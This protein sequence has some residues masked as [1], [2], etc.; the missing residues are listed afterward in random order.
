MKL[1]SKEEQHVVSGADLLMTQI[2]STADLSD[3]CVASIVLALQN[4]ALTEEQIA[5]TILG[6]CTFNELDILDERLDS[7]MPYSVEI[8]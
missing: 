2:I 8:I 4:K 6:G 5:S 3:K 7:T 1:L